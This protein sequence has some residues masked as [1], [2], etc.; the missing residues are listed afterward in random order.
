[1]FNQKYSESLSRTGAHAKSCEFWQIKST[2]VKTLEDRG[3]SE[4]TTHAPP[5]LTHLKFNIAPENIPSP[6]ESSLPT[7]SF[8]RGYV[9]HRGCMYDEGT[10]ITES[11]NKSVPR[12]S[13]SKTHVP[14]FCKGNGEH[15]TILPALAVVFLNKDPRSLY[16]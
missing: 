12:W 3:K 9:K 4:R 6:K 10:I 15:R 7:S 2:S 1:M 13:M 16:G 8:F 11:S 5:Q 14:R